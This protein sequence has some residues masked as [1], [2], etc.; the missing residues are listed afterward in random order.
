MNQIEIERQWNQWVKKHPNR[1]LGFSYDNWLREYKLMTHHNE[2]LVSSYRQGLNQFTGLDWDQKISMFTGSIP[3]TEEDRQQATPICDMLSAHVGMFRP[4]WRPYT[5]GGPVPAWVDFRD[6]DFS[7]INGFVTV[8][9]VKN[10]GPCGSCVIFSGT[11]FLEAYIALSTDTD[12]QSISAQQ[13][14]N[15]FDI[16]NFLNQCNGNVIY[17][18][19]QKLVQ[20][21]SIQFLLAQTPNMTTVAD[22]EFNDPV[23][24]AACS[25]LNQECQKWF[26]KPP[27]CTTTN[28]KVLKCN[29]LISCEISN[30]C[31]PQYVNP[32]S[33]TVP[34]CTPNFL[35]MGNSVRFSG[36]I[37]ARET[38]IAESLC[39]YGPMVVAVNTCDAFF[40]YQ[41]GIFQP[42]QNTN[43]NTTHA[44]LLIGYSNDNGTLPGFLIFKNSWGPDWAKEGGYFRLPRGANARAYGTNGPMNIYTSVS[45]VMYG[46]SSA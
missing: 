29:S 40:R 1:L 6:S 39:Q 35:T 30:T 25:T 19:F 14:L 15:V 10:Q 9:P 42:P 23:K 26:L 21:T 37:E 41:S 12:A 17:K 20:G 38:S 34:T 46:Y 22:Y 13:L 45:F 33:C 32:T 43:D 31:L 3:P 5:P 24:R 44:V 16:T 4:A 8:T 36:T 27:A 7:S 18:F 11:A 2:N 28:P